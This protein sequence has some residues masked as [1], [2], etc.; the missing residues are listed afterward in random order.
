[1]SKHDQ[2]NFVTNVVG[3][4]GM[5]TSDVVKKRQTALFA[6]VDHS[7]GRR[8]AQGINITLS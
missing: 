5:A 7:L 1:M 4:L 3:H 2:E 8:I 6:K